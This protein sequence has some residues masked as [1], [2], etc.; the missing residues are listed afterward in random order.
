MQNKTKMII[1]LGSA[2]ALTM[3]TGANRRES[4][5]AARSDNK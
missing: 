3:G 2:D 4:H 5:D 1:E